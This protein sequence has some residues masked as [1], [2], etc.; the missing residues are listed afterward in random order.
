MSGPAP[1]AVRES[2]VAFNERGSPVAS[3]GDVMLVQEALRHLGLYDGPIDGI[4]GART[5]IALRAYKRRHGMGV[6]DRL[7]PELVEHVRSST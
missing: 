4:A 3:T 2:P 7:G 5:R 6:D 1:D